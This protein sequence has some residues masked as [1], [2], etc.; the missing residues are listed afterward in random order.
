MV[1]NNGGKKKKKKKKNVPKIVVPFVYASSQGQRTHSART[2]TNLC[3][4]P[5][6]CTLMFNR[7]SKIIFQIS[8]YISD[9]K[10]DMMD[11]LDLQLKRIDVEDLIKMT[12]TKLDFKSLDLHK[13]LMLKKTLKQA[14][15]ALKNITDLEQDLFGKQDDNL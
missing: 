15:E 10:M 12:R 2:N 1:L 5:D 8:D 9:S 11:P 13:K 3:G 6:L 14:I 4:M 7:F